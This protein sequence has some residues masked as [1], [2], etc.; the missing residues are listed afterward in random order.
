MCT[1]DCRGI[2]VALGP[3]ALTDCHVIRRLSCMMSSSFD[4][5]CKC[6]LATRR[7]RNRRNVDRSP[8]LL[9]L[10]LLCCFTQSHAILQAAVILPHGDEALDPST[11][12][13]PR[14]RQA[15]E[16][17]HRAA[18]SSTQ[19][20]E[21]VIRPDYIFLSTP[22]GVAL[23]NDFAIYLDATA[24]GSASIGGDAWHA[25]AS[26]QVELP[27]IL[28]A[29]E[30]STELLMDWLS[31][32][33]VAGV[34]VSADADNDAI[35]RWAEVIPL[36]L[37]GPPR[38][39]RR[40]LILSH[41]LR[42]YE[43][44]PE[45]TRELLDLGSVLFEWMESRPER[46]AVMVSGDLSHTHRADGPYGYSHASESFDRAIYTWASN[47]CRSEYADEL[48]TTSRDLQPHAL[49]CGYTGFVLLHGILCGASS[50][51]RWYPQ[52]DLSDQPTGVE[53]WESKVLVNTNATYFGMMVAQYKRSDLLV[54]SQ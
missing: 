11:I 21:Q 44:G 19:W 40:H 5:P 42:R 37:L 17:I 10:L 18:A 53:P 39:Y 22:H 31:G 23:S 50:A 33:N 8:L 15:A 46:F 48:L 13:D 38:A 3:S 49:S 9:L 47:P 28:L 24:S 51:T 6:S 26:R 30:L 14:G 32:N 12:I 20:L 16:H 36:L 29:P 35:L 52:D 7:R 41:P 1:T 54:T 4:L 25:N 45:M 2:D 27:S 34:Q 43:H